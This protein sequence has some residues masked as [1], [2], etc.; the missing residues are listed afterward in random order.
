MNHP[1]LYNSL[2]ALLASCAF[3]A[4]AQELTYEKTIKIT[5]NAFS[6]RGD[7]LYVDLD[8]DVK[9]INFS[10]CGSLSLIPLLVS[11]TQTRALPEIQLKGR[12]NYRVYRRELALM[13]KRERE[14]YLK[15]APYKVVRES[16]KEESQFIHYRYAL[17]F[18][19][20]MANSQLAIKQEFC[21]CGASQNIAMNRLVDN[22][23]LDREVTTEPYSIVPSLAYM[24]PT[25]E[26]IKSRELENE[27]FLDFA[28]S[29]TI[30]RPEFKNNPAELAKIKQ[31]IEEVKNDKATTIRRIS[32]VGYASP[33][34]LL[35]T[36]KNLSEARAKALQS[37]LNNLYDIPAALYSIEF[38]GEDWEGLSKLIR[39]SDIEHKEEILSIIEKVD[40]LNGRELQ[41]MNYQQGVPYRYMLQNMFP[42][43]R[44]VVITV[45]YD[46]KTWE[47]SQAKEL[48]QSRPQHLSLN[49]MYLVANT[50]QQGSKE[51][52]DIF[53]IAV[54]MYP[55][56]ETANLNAA[57]A[58]LSRKD[59]IYG[60]RY[61]KL[62]TTPSAQY[63]NNLGVL[64]LL[65][66]N[67]AQAE[68]VLLIAQKAG[69]KE[70][71]HNLEELAKKRASLLDSE[72]QPK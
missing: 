31:M 22:L 57:A 46:V 16:K 47:V 32:I 51:F 15:Q 42:L 48:I 19:P 7:S 30:I 53:E 17:A 43:L 14:T 18:E 38:G 64:Q 52:N 41:L 27:S 49:E 2:V 3:T 40:V 5:P 70:A 55:H 12:S 8:I 10:S 34:G 69:S 62:V 63:N 54:R 13:N 36:N 33:E 71:Q 29:Q 25:P 58:A 65:I 39:A 35:L 4:Q 44:R 20:W 1:Y 23:S 11:N 60:E 68:R 61:L 59:V 66:G 21:G 45:H 56:D 28:A 50:Y 6:Q 24:Q 26:L 9:K 72:K 67:Y 37:Y